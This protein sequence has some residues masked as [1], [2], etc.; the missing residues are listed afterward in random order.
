MLSVAEDAPTRTAESIGPSCPC[1][2]AHVGWNPGNMAVCQHQRPCFGYYPSPSRI[3][4]GQARA[5]EQ[6]GTANIPVGGGGGG[7]GG[8]G[9]F[10]L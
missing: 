6:E 4:R 1:R 2:L 9:E 3:K 5:R 10:P 8:G 7:G